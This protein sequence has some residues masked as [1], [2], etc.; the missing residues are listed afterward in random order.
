MEMLQW[1]RYKSNYSDVVDFLKMGNLSR[2]SAFLV[3][4]LESGFT[5]CRRLWS[6]IGFCRVSRSVC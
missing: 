2:D 5:E 3:L 1:R 4:S 6:E